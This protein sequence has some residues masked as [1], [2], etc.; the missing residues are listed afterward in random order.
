MAT[1]LKTAGGRLVR[2]IVRGALDR[3]RVALGLWT[4]FLLTAGA[5]A[6]QVRVDATIG[7]FLNRDGEAWEY[8]RSSVERF[9]G[10]EFIAV[11][12]TGEAPLAPGLLETTERLS[13]TFESHGQVRRVDSLAT[14]PLIR[15]EADGALSLAPGLP[16]AG[17]DPERARAD[18][19]RHLHD[20]PVAPRLLVGEDRRTTAVN[21]LVDGGVD[22]DLDPL[23]ESAWEIARKEGAAISGVPVFRHGVSD[24]TR[25]EVYR[26][27][28]ITLAIACLLLLATFRSAVAV[29]ATTAVAAVAIAGCLAAMVMGGSALS[30]STMILPSV[31]LGLSAAYVIHMLVA[32][33]GGGEG[34]SDHERMLEVAAPVALSG[35]TTSLG[36]LAMATVRIQVIQD[37]ALYGSFGTAV[38]A[39]AAISLAPAIVALCG[40]VGRAHWGWLGR[41]WLRALDRQLR[42]PR[43]V[44]SLWGL[45]LAAVVVGAL[46][47]EVSSNIIPWFPQGSAIRDA[48]ESVRSRLSGIT[49]VNV[50]IEL[51][52]GAS[53][54]EPAVLAEVQRFAAEL[55]RRP[56]VGRTLSLVDPLLAVHRALGEA[57]SEPFPPG[58]AAAEQYLLLLEGVEQLGDV[59]APDRRSLNV[60]VRM[61]D[62]SSAAILA[63]ADAVEAWWAV[64]ATPGPVASVRTTGI[65]Y[66]FARAQHEIAWGQVRGLAAALVLIGAVVLAVFSE[67][68][69]ALVALIPNLL[70][71]MATFGVLGWTGVPLDAATVCI[72]AMALGIAVDDTIHVCGRFSREKARGLSDREAVREAVFQVSPAITTTTVMLAASF[73]ALSV[74]QFTL[75]QSLGLVTGGVMA[76]CLLA[77]V[78]LLPV[79]L[80]GQR[81]PLDQRG[82]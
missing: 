67:V 14:V 29:A 68:W 52:P 69:I 41:F 3:P 33:S 76:L 55:E 59:L 58:R 32:A 43:T 38:A 7:S 75:V 22:A 46:R 45:V 42:W 40:G 56:D 48:Y 31:L 28:P 64:R 24:W 5:V 19:A 11:A 49:P 30:V 51:E 20:D 25:R 27:A 79:L 50:V 6:S 77:D 82:R 8:Y 54:T 37:L 47:I 36:F 34:A 71:V 80:A 12:L 18:F 16:L 53:A 15:A 1:A 63:L 72:A 70:P 65:M 74:S 26:F 66:E 78:S 9:G 21:L 73:L 57:E 81:K 62:N 2:R 44:V 4:L 10:D 13:A 23:V 61:D 35:F 17:G 60:R 39:L